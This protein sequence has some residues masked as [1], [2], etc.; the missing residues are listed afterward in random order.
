[1]LWPANYRNGS[2]VRRHIPLKGANVLRPS[3]AIA[4]TS[5]SVM[6]RCYAWVLENAPDFDVVNHSRGA[7]S[8]TVLPYAMGKIDLDRTDFLVIDVL[9]NEENFVHSGQTTVE[10]VKN[11]L[12]SALEAAAE[13][14]VVPI[15]LSF[16]RQ[17]FLNR[18]RVVHDTMK[19]LCRD[20]GVVFVDMYDMI[21]VAEQ[22]APVQVY[23]KSFFENVAHIKRPISRMVGLRLADAI[24]RSSRS[25]MVT[26]SEHGVAFDQVEFCF[27][28]PDMGLFERQNG[29]ATEQIAALG[30]GDR[31]E[32]I[33]GSDVVG[34]GFNSEMTDCVVSTDSDQVI[35]LRGP[36]KAE[37]RELM[38]VILPTRFRSSQLVVSGQPEG[39]FEFVGYARHTGVRRTQMRIASRAVLPVPE[40][41]D[42]FHKDIALVA[43]S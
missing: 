26:A 10:D 24:R 4:G 21:E 39:R 32:L 1:M 15:V 13:H 35:S 34:I 11:N 6:A 36:D 12:C 7:S 2:T 40:F 38:T 9:N 28:N 25:E 33:G 37:G 17:N 31:I 18:E 3:I 14:G 30:V 42:Q 27:P 5:N 29:F 20:L 41:D 8:S 23:K 22:Q 43:V 16:P 19:A